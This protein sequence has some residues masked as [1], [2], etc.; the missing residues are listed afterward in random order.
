MI[1]ATS[2]QRRN[3]LLTSVVLMFS[4]HA[5]VTFG[6]NLKLLDANCTFLP[7]LECFLTGLELQILLSGVLANVFVVTIFVFF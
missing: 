2:R 3:L 7:K 6:D 5:G 1:E 4:R